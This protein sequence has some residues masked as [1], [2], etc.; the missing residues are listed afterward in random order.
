MSG[1]SIVDQPSARVVTPQP[2]RRDYRCVVVAASMGGPPALYRFLPELCQKIRLPILVVQH[3]MGG[4]TTKFAHELNRRC[5]AVSKY[6]VHEA[7]Q[8]ML[9]RPYH[10]YLAPGDFHMSLRSSIL[11]L[12][13][14]APRENGCR[15][16]A[17]VL[18]RTAAAAL[19]GA[20]VGVV[21]TGM[22][23]DGTLGAQRIKAL[24][25]WMMAQD[26]ATSA[27]WGMPRSVVMAGL[28]DEILPLE[29]MADGVARQIQQG[30]RDHY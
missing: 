4:F 2:V 12:D 10:V 9:V 28:A 13:N 19:S 29:E 7:E 18:F 25:G 26:K 21:L 6:Q 3:M 23:S 1:F 30:I 16:A 27:V 11:H 15:P 17:D 8:L 20:V 14:M 5:N 22:G 24:G